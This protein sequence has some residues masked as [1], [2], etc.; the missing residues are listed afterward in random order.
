MG[1]GVNDGICI[2]KSELG[3]S[4]VCHYV[5]IVEGFDVGLWD[6]I[7]WFHILFIVYTCVGIPIPFFRGLNPWLVS[8]SVFTCEVLGNP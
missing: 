3:S 4:A 7:L 6:T 5:T 1:L 8:F 2:L